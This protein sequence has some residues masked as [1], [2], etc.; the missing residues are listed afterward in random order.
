MVARSANVAI[1][2]P[3]VRSWRTG[4]VFAVEVV[5]RPGDLSADDWWEL[6]MSGYP[7]RR[8]GLLR[9][10]GLPDKLLRLGVRYADGTK[11]TT[12]GGTSLHDPAA[13]HHSH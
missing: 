10:D 11:A 13:A 4:C 6:L 12:V 2:V 5:S 7:I 8:P 9:G 1:I 3:I